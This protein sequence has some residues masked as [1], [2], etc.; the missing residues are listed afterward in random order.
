MVWGHFG[1]LSFGAI[2]ALNL[3]PS[4]GT[5]SDTFGVNLNFIGAVLEFAVTKMTTQKMAPLLNGP[6]EKSQFSPLL[7]HFGKP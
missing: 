6:S 2:L 5:E 3:G 7:D 4:F 1:N